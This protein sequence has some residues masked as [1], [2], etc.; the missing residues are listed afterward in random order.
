MTFGRGAAA[1]TLFAALDASEA[2]TARESTL[3]TSPTARLFWYCEAIVAGLAAMPFALLKLPGVAELV[4]RLRPTGYNQ[5]GELLPVLP[6]KH[7]K[8]KHRREEELQR[9][10][11]KARE[12]EERQGDKKGGSRGAPSGPV[13]AA[14]SMV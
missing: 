14:S 10:R 3:H 7:V 12:K 2:P 8:M 1:A 4:L 13:K 6:F 9:M 5:A 11:R